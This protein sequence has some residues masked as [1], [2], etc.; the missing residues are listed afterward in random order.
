MSLLD[1]S[2]SR[3]SLTSG[4]RKT[5]DTTIY[6]DRWTAAPIEEVEGEEA[7]EEYTN[8]WKLTKYKSRDGSPDL[9]K[10]AQIKPTINTK[11]KSKS[12]SEEPTCIYRNSYEC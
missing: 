3:L 11:T 9:K 6:K 10:N 1:T 4:E 8:T 12:I 7:D 5:N 2:K